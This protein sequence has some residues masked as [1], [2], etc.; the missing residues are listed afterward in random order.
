ML[1]RIAGYKIDVFVDPR[2]MRHN[3]IAKLIGSNQKLRRAIG[4]VPITPTYET[5]EWMFGHARAEFERK[6]I[7]TLTTPR[8]TPH[9]PALAT[10]GVANKPPQSIR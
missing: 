9:Q 7:E 2:F 5:L 6:T 3:E 8:A 1:E 4:R 10:T